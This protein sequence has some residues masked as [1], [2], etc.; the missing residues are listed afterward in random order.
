MY[1]DL[2]I[3]LS[4]AVTGIL[5]GA[6]VTDFASPYA[7][8]LLTGQ[9]V[10]LDMIRAQLQPDTNSES[11]AELKL[12]KVGEPGFIALS[13]LHPFLG[14]VNDLTEPGTNRLGFLGE[15]A[16][17]KKSPQTLVI[18]ITGGSVAMFFFIE[19]VLKKELV[20]IDLFKNKEIQIIDL[21]LGGYKQPQQLN[22]LVYHLALGAQFDIIVNLD[23]FNEVVLPIAENKSRGVAPFFP[24]LWDIFSAKGFSTEK[25][26]KMALVIGMRE[27]VNQV[28][29]FFG[30]PIIRDSALMNILWR[31]WS[32]RKFLEMNKL[33]DELAKNEATYQSTGPKTGFLTDD[34]YLVSLIDIWE[35]SSLQMANLCSANGIKY[36]HL[37]QPNQ[38][39]ERKNLSAEEQTV[40]I[41]PGDYVYK[42]AVKKGYP[43]LRS[44]GEELKKRGVNFVDLTDIFKTEQR[45]IYRD[46][47]CHINRLGNEE[48]A[49]HV[50]S[51]ISK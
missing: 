30:W 4:L 5:I 21:A 24:R 6:F 32:Q 14:Y 18:G 36:F 16:P 45:T 31:E 23:G 27:Q 46:V 42:T 44:R 50:A 10:E 39:D 38:Y 17:K 49:K 8:E 48:L 9:K 7:Y 40:A 12:P 51:I 15:E 13:V 11:I 20:K 41:L 28:K 1:R 26:K 35:N 33:N 19:E 29:S 37:L 25:L 22:A 3:G 34:Q 47:C 2:I 43:L